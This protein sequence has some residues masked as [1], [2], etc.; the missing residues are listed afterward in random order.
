[1]TEFHK[2]NLFKLHVGLWER[3]IVLTNGSLAFTHPPP[4]LTPTNS[5]AFVIDNYSRC[6]FFKNAF[7]KKTKTSN[8]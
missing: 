4:Q 2:I 7:C 6:L 1:M 8:F 5:L 3:G